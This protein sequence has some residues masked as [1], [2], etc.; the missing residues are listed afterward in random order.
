M[1]LASKPTLQSVFKPIGLWRKRADSV[2]RLAREMN[3]RGGRFPRK[4]SE[5]DKLPAVGQYIANAIELFVFARPM[6]LIDVNM[7]RVIERYFGSRLLADIRY[8]PYLQATAKK[9]VTC[10]KLAKM[11]WAVLDL[12]ALICRS[13]SPRCNLCPLKNGCKFNS[14]TIGKQRR[15]DRNDKTKQE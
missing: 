2:F 13:N 4:R 8:D 10:D 5:I 7:A 11:N 14:T 15:R 1:A 3:N 12:A 9:L 6:P